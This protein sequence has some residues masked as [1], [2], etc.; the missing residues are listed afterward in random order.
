MTCMAIMHGSKAPT[1]SAMHTLESGE[2]LL[3]VLPQLLELGLI[4]NVPERRRQDAPLSDQM[5]EC[6]GGSFIV[7]PV[8]VHLHRGPALQSVLKILSLLDD[9]SQL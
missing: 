5:E 2:L 4:L 6:G 3:P 8:I 9:L 7:T 1:R